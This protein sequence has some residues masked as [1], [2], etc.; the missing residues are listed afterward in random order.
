MHYQVGFEPLE[1]LLSLSQVLGFQG[2]Q[3]SWLSELSMYR[4]LHLKI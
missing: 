4:K 1:S 3:H 2:C